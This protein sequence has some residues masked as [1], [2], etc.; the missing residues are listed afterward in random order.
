MQAT[1]LPPLLFVTG[2]DTGVGKTVASAWLCRQMG[3]SYWKPIQTGAA[4]GDDDTG[5]LRS[6]EVKTVA[7]ARVFAHSSAPEYAAM[8]EGQCVTIAEL[9]PELPIPRPLVIEGAGGVLVPINSHETMLDLM[10]ALQRKYAHEFGVVVVTRIG[11]GTINHTLL[12]LM[13]LRKAE[14]PI[15]GVILNGEDHPQNREAIAR[16]GHVDILTQIPLL[17]CVDSVELDHVL[18]FV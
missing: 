5:V 12:T 11:L 13:A 18:P 15:V 1:K 2:T 10:V 7:P 4:D 16:H 8:L 14:L 3:A 17:R 6:C 9:L